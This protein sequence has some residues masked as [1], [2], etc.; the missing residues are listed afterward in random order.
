MD[1]MCCLTCGEWSVLDPGPRTGSTVICQVCGAEAQ[2][3]DSSLPLDWAGNPVDAD[4]DG[5]MVFGREFVPAQ[6]LCWS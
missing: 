3:G 5:E 6:Y 2:V 1:M 4:G